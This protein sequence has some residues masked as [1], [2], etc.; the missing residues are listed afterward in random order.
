MPMVL[1][2]SRE[3]ILVLAPVG[4]DASVIK[5]TLES[6]GIRA[7]AVDS[8][9]TICEQIHIDHGLGVAGLI[10]TEEALSDPKHSEALA[11]CLESQPP[12]SDLPICVLTVPGDTP[13]TIARW[14]L[15]ETL[16]N[17]MLL[18]RPLTAE[19]LQSVARG[20]IRGRSRQRQT[21]QHL[22]ALK[23]AAYTLERRVV[24]RTQ[25]LMAAEETLRQA[26]KMEAVG[27]LTGG[28]AHDFNNLLQVLATNMELMK[29]RLRQGRYI[30]LEA[31]VQS[32]QDATHRAA[33]TAGVFAATNAR[34]EAS[35][36]QRTGRRH[37]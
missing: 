17:V 16:G 28:V 26:Q 32:A 34:P 20:I 9:R 21:M 23:D 12:W 6:S 13:S 1:A 14:R 22:E 8:I 24:E 31:H 30:D 36:A 25:E 10:F 18:A 3:A 29:L 4:Q 35:K 15:F 37:A 2:D 19:A 7:E 5:A 11:A 27:Q 33:S